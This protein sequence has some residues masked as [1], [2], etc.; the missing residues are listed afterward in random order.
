MNLI[1]HGDNDI[2]LAHQEKRNTNLYPDLIK[3][4]NVEHGD[5]MK[6]CTSSLH[7]M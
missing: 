3:P 7:N 1:K 6:K 2:K 5:A 4:S